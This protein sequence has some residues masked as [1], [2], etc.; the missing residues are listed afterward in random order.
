MNQLRH[1]HDH[2]V[3]FYQDDDYLIRKI[4]KY[5]READAAV[6]IMT[7]RHARMLSAYLPDLNIK[8]LT[9]LDARATLAQFMDGQ[10]PNPVKFER[11]IGGKL[12][13]LTRDH[14][15]IKA[16]GEMVALLWESGNRDGAIELEK[17]WNLLGLQ[18]RFSLLCA[19]PMHILGGDESE[20]FFADMCA[21]HSDVFPTEQIEYLHS[22]EDRF[23]AISILEQRSVTLDS[24]RDRRR[25]SEADLRKLVVE[26]E[27]REDDFISATSHELKTPLTSQFGYI[28][29]LRQALEEDSGDKSKRFLTKIEEQTV[30]LSKLIAN[31][32]DS[33]KIGEGMLKLTR[34]E[35]DIMELI[36]SCTDE[37]RQFSKSRQIKVEGEIHRRIPLDRKRISQVLM[38]LLSNAIKYSPASKTVY[39]SVGEGAG[40]I[41]VTIRDS[42]IGITPEDQPKV[43][44]RFFRAGENNGRTYPGLGLGLYIASEIIRLHGGTIRVD[45]AIGKGA[46]FSFWLPNT[47]AP[48]L[49]AQP[50]QYA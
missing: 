20:S 42:G 6:L 4:L 43:F 49:D 3:Q 15:N 30:K 47:Y 46:A 5:L 38:S 12:A 37:I 18:H 1:S 40:G 13:S 7:P 33:V 19:Y 39:I 10:A 28:A 8:N 45:S 22:A 31:L 11:V 48:T 14:P 24:E 35:T 50:A 27:M 36:G 34:E 32:V 9:V 2:A 21:T 29:L 16:F 41:E 26:L 23:R 25:K 44:G 17:L